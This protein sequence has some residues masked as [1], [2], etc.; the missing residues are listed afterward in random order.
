M[1][2]TNTKIQLSLSQ[3]KFLKKSKWSGKY[4][5]KKIILNWEDNGSLHVQIS[6]ILE[7]VM[8]LY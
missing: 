1:S 7:K 6:S 4:I 5:K 3:K 8:E 2:K